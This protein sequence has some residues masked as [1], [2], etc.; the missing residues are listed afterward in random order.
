MG[1]ATAIFA[2]CGRNDINFIVADSSFLAIKTLCEEVAK[3]NYKLPNF[4]L[5]MVYN[6]I[7]KKILNKAKFDLNHVDVLGTVKNPKY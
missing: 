2:G 4:I 1:A 3:K 5:A 7:R 6:Y